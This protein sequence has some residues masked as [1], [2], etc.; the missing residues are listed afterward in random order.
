MATNPLLLPQTAE[1]DVCPS[2]D[3]EGLRE[4]AALAWVIVSDRAGDARQAIAIA[5]A[6]G[7]PY[8]VHRAIPIGGSL[9]NRSSRRRDVIEQLDPTRSSSFDAPRPSFILTIGNWPTAT[10]LSLQRRFRAPP[11]IVLIGRPKPGQFD[12]FHTIV[13][14]SQYLVPA[15]PKVIRM[16]FPPHDDECGRMG[17]SAAVNTSLASLRRPITAVFVGGP[18]SP[19]RFDTNV[20]RDLVD[21]ALHVR[22]GGDLFVVTGP[23]TPPA[24]AH[25]LR[26]RAN[27]A[28]NVFLWGIDDAEL[29]PYSA[30]LSHADRFIVTGDSLST[31][32]DVAARGRPMAIFDLPVRSR[33][34]SMWLAARGRMAAYAARSPHARRMLL[35]LHRLRLAGFARDLGALHRT[36]IDRGIASSLGDGPFRWPRATV[37]DELSRVGAQIRR[38]LATASDGQRRAAAARPIGPFGAAR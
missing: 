4:P 10:A 17:S 6:I 22:G 1:S 19:F 2:R 16:S 13:A 38:A 3:I 32:M 34:S 9:Q 28:K 11:P 24:V 29:N 7:V 35:V 26:H 31:L 20:A 23:R 25:M 18:T 30:L 15:H 36:L 33:L 12:R 5:N 14:S 21:R 8:Q 37:P 27:V